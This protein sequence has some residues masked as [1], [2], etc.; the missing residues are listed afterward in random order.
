[1]SNRPLRRAALALAAGLLA[2]APVQAQEDRFAAIEIKTQ[3]VAEGIYML[4]GEGGNIGVSVGADGVFMID[5]QFAP[6]S[7]KIKAAVAALSDQPIR[8]LIN[9]HWHYDHTGGN[10]LLAGEGVIIVAHHNVRKRMSVDTEIAAF[11]SVVPASPKAA[12]PVLTF[13]DNLTLHLNGDEARVIHYKNSHTDGDSLIHFVNANVIHTG[14]LWFNG[15]YPFMDISSGGSVSGAIKT[16]KAIL[17]LADD[18]TRIIPGHG[19]LGDKQAMRDY[20]VMLETVSGRMAKLIAAGK[21]IDEI[22]ALKPNADYDET[23]GRDFL[24]PDMFLRILYD[25]QRAESP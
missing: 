16:I 1:M 19:P 13:N 8:F 5:D 10:E 22:I 20:L 17:A 7:E 11:G 2:S 15:L 3:K 14:D 18:D 4:T 21:S 23:W 12:L 25:L 9:T 6:L 24:K